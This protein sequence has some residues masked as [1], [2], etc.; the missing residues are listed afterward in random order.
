[1][2]Q[3]IRLCDNCGIRAATQYTKIIINGV[4]K[5]MSLCAECQMKMGIGNTFE[6][7]ESM[8]K[9]FGFYGTDDEYNTGKSS[10]KCPKCGFSLN[11]YYAT[12]YLGCPDCYQAFEGPLSTSI[13]RLQ[14]DIRHTG[15]V[16]KTAFSPEE[17]EYANLLKAREEAVKRE[18]F[19]AAA[20]IN[21][22]MKKLKGGA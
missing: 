14:K 9:P 2:E 3:K 1:M 19:V 22:K 4:S 8:L 18:D 7:M 16:P 20:E 21:E 11:D 10:L 17:Q 6:Q 5:T 12:G 15:K 13:K